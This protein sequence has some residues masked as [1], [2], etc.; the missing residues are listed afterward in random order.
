MSQPFL[1]T[2]PHAGRIERVNQVWRE[3]VAE[4]EADRKWRDRRDRKILLAAL[5]CWFVALGAALG[6]L[7]FGR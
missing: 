4:E 3:A 2:D 6:Y 7:F 5:G 1:V